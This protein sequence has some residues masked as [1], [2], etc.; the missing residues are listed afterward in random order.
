V[1]FRWCAVL[2]GCI[3]LSA[4]LPAC[5]NGNPEQAFEKGRTLDECVDNVPV[6][7]TVASCVLTT[8]NYVAGSFSGGPP[9]RF[10]VTTG[11]AALVSLNVYFTEETSPGSDT[12]ITWFEAACASSAVD[13]TD[14]E[15]IFV[16]AGPGR[17]WSTT[18]QFTTGGD[19][20]IELVSDA[21]AS[22]LL[23]VTISNVQ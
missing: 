8:S 16:A 17:V 9:R 4:A 13:A 21:Q 11:G 19:H 15:D 7:T 6:C 1:P 20:L 3:A 14:G 10:V 18:H 23:S 5:S 22:Y 12:E 2:T